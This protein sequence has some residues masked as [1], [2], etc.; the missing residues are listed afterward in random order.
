MSLVILTP[1]EIRALIDQRIQDLIGV[2]VPVTQEWINSIIQN[3]ITIDQLNTALTA[4]ATDIIQLLDSHIS[5]SLTSYVTQDAFASALS[6]YL[7]NVAASSLATRD[8]LVALGSSFSDSLTALNTAIQALVTQDQLRAATRATIAVMKTAGEAPDVDLVFVKNTSQ[9]LINPNTNLDRDLQ[10]FY[11]RG[12]A[13][14][15]I[16]GKNGQIIDGGKF[17]VPAPTSPSTPVTVRLT[18]DPE[19]TMMW[20][21]N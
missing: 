3:L 17:T 6:G 2:N 1:D 15:D 14:F 21:R 13:P 16:A 19:N 20:V 8:E 10:Y 18:R 7:T 4:K 11:A 5:S 9:V 12:T